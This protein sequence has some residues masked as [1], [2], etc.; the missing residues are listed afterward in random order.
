MDFGQHLP[1]II[2]KTTDT[3][4]YM[5]SMF[6]DDSTSALSQ[7]IIIV[8]QR[9]GNGIFYG[10]QSNDCR[11]TFNVGKHLFKGST[12]NQLYLFPFKI[13]VG[14]NVMKTSNLSLYRY[15]FHNSFSDHPGQGKIYFKHKK[16]GPTLHKSGTVSYI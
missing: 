8:Q 6:S 4:F 16:N 15:S 13:L 1:V 5:Q 10:C 9:S 12:T 11:V 14:C 3:M 7:Q 2:R